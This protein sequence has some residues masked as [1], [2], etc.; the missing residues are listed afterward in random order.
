MPSSLATI[1]SAANE[2]ESPLVA[3]LGQDDT[4]EGTILQ[5][6]GAPVD[7]TAGDVGLTY[8]VLAYYQAAVPEMTLTKSGGAITGNAEGEY[9]VLCSSAAKATAGL[10]PGQYYYTLVLTAAGGSSD[11][12]A[13]GPLYVV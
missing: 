13:R 3:V 2:Q 6:G 12:V 10:R 11:M 1:L 8:K 5:V 4:F 7:L 9:S